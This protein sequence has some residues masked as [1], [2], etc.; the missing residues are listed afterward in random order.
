M[1]D[2]KVIAASIVDPEAFGA[3]F[4]RHYD[5]VT[6]YV[7]QRVGDVVGEDIT[8]RTFTVAFARRDRFA[9]SANSARPW[10]YGIATNLI[11]H[12][13]RDERTHL[14]LRGRVP[15]PTFE[16]D[17]NQDVAHLDAKRLAGTIRDAL[18]ALPERDREPL[19]L[20][21]LG[22]FTYEEIA[23]A[24]GIPSGTAKSRVNRARRLLR[25]RITAATGIQ[26]WTAYLDE[27]PDGDG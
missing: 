21:V 14:A 5:A 23:T 6:S 12:H 16:P 27:D 11:R 3:I 19:L 25:E 26:S 20:H 7:G 22:E 13:T 24:L 2:G 15:I 8:A 4:E 1:H 9:V 10:L 17:P 18:L